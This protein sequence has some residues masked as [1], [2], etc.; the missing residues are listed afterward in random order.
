MLLIKIEGETERPYTLSYFSLFIIKINCKT[1]FYL[2]YNFLSIILSIF[3][4]ELY[5]F[6]L[7]YEIQ[8]NTVSC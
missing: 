1:Y 3:K 7:F 6:R 5:L 4:K 2:V 8:K